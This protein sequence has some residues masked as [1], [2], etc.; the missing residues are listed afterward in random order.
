MKYLNNDTVGFKYKLIEFGLNLAITLC[1][2][3]NLLKHT[4]D[5]HVSLSSTHCSYKL[6]TRSK[7]GVYNKGGCRFE[8]KPE[9]FKI[10]LFFPQ[11]MDFFFLF[12]YTL[13][14][15]ALQ[16]PGENH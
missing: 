1:W 3:R 15:L 9:D 13:A 2:E 6:G 5:W 12:K 4:F 7:A 10:N 11:K 8:M 16:I 14:W